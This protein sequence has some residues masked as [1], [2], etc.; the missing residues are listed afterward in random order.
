[1]KEIGSI[2]FLI[3]SQL[4]FSQNPAK[5]ILKKDS[6]KTYLI[7]KDVNEKPEFIGGQ[8]EMNNFIVSNIRFPEKVKKDSS[9][10]ACKVYV[11]FEVDTSGKVLNPQ[12]IRGCK[13][14]DACDLEALRGVRMMPLWKPAI[15]N[16]KKVKAVYSVPISFRLQ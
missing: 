11:K 16:G 14:F 8:E 4:G 1:M 6:T 10:C 5:Y 9:F 3:L 12:I 15:S 13:G 2:I 7:N